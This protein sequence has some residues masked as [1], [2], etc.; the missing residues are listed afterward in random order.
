[1]SSAT[2]IAVIGDVHG[3]FTEDDAV[4]IDALDLDGVLFVG[5]LGGFRQA[6]TVATASC[7]SALRTPTWVLPGN[8]DG[9]TL[10]QLGAE[11]MGQR[12]LADRLS[13]GMEQR[14]ETLR[15]L[16]APAQLVAYE[17][18][19]VGEHVHVLAA[20]PHSFGGPALS[21]QA[22]LARAYG[23]DDLTASAE[24]L[25]SLVA[26]APADRTVVFLAH[27]GP[28][29]LGNTRD[30]PFGRDFHR[31]GGDWGDSDLRVAIEHATGLGLRAAVVAGHMHHALRGGGKRQ[32]VGDLE[33][34][35]CI[36]AARVPRVDSRGRS[37]HVRLEISGEGV[38]IV[39]VL[40]GPHGSERVLV[41]S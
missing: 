1:M 16:L 18:F 6:T 23:V 13:S 20:R 39:D 19:D 33:G 27:N 32:T 36:N 22:Y 10:P 40:L 35:P 21:Y 28:T 31:D 12:G 5:D 7:I 3:R 30:A 38:R 26:A 25:V 17:G 34:V 29:G 24:R 11:A 15:G 2:R 4:Q 37:H 8:H 14:V 9:A 41:S